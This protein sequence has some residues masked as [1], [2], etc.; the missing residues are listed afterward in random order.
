[1]EA[2]AIMEIATVTIPIPV[3]LRSLGRPRNTRPRDLHRHRRAE[4]FS[5]ALAT[6]FKE[7]SETLL[8]R[9]CL[10]AVAAARV[11]AALVACSVAAGTLVRWHKTE[12]VLDCS[13]RIP[14]LVRQ[15]LPTAAQPAITANTPLLAS[16]MRRNLRLIQLRH[17]LPPTA[18]M[19]GE[20]KKVTTHYVCHLHN[21]WW[22]RKLWST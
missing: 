12:A 19:G 6:F 14:A 22:F 17:P 4:A 2:A 1:M 5:P 3:D 15:A 16:A 7:N 20:H 9:L 10:I 21:L 13:T 18:A 8:A 11:E